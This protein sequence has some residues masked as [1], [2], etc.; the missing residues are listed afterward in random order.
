MQLSCVYVPQFY[1]YTKP[2]TRQ[3]KRGLFP[4]YFVISLV[5]FLVLEIMPIDFFL[6][7]LSPYL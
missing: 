6:N 7:G 5:F 1:G 3:K 4:M 2:K